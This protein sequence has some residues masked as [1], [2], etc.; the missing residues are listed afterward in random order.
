MDFW[1]G[2][3]IGLTF[4]GIVLTIIGYIGNKKVIPVEEEI[5]ISINI[6]DKFIDTKWEENVIEITKISQDRE[7]VKYKFI[8]LDKRR[9]DYSPEYSNSIDFILNSGY[10]KRLNK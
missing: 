1:I 5:K 8:E 6:G 4:I 9:I 10:Y 2:T 7:D 3:I